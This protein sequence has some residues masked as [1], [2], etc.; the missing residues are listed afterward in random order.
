MR[1]HV[2]TVVLL[3]ALGCAASIRA[4]TAEILEHAE[5]IR[6]ELQP[7]GGSFVITEA[8]STGVVDSLTL[9]SRHQPA[10][11]R[12]VPAAGGVYYAICPAR[13]RCPYPG[14]RAA[15]VRARV[16]RRVALDLALRTFQRTAAGVVVVSLPTSRPAL[17]VLER[18]D[19]MTAAP[20][21]LERLTISNVYAMRAH[22]AISDNADTLVL[23]QVS[24][25]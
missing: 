17:V 15:R 20:D 7:S 21:G 5:Q 11:M 18:D 24:A 14:R 8:S 4:G 19:V 10:A 12:V 1:R 3:L 22:I 23:E 2:F 9:L 6:S 13:A 25:R 16:P